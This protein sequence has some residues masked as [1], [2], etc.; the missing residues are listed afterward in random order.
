MCL[1]SPNKGDAVSFEPGY[2]VVNDEFTKSGKYNLTK[3]SHSSRRF[4]IEYSNFYAFHVT[5]QAFLSEFVAIPILISPRHA[6]FEV[7][8]SFNINLGQSSFYIV[9][10]P[11]QEDTVL[12]P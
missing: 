4:I 6:C 10:R 1:W 5:F 9:D 8:F 12:S 3:V 2:P 7:Y 11:Q